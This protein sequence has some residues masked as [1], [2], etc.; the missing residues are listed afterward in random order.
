MQYLNPID[1]DGDHFADLDFDEV[2]R[3]FIGRKWLGIVD[4]HI[5]YRPRTERLALFS[6][7]IA[8][9]PDFNPAT[10]L[11][12]LLADAMHWS[13]ANEIAFD[14]APNTATLHFNNETAICRSAAPRDGL[15]AS[16]RCRRLRRN[17]G[18]ARRD[19]A[20]PNPE[21]PM[22]RRARGEWPL[23]VPMRRQCRRGFVPK[24]SPWRSRRLKIGAKKRP[25]VLDLRQFNRVR[26]SGLEP[27]TYG[28]KV[29]CSTN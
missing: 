22:S 1:S 27:E 11:V 9:Y 16:G 29:R 7:A 28:L 19:P 26:L 12:D 21:F 23:R 15:T 4:Y 6:N 17:H 25:Q 8:C 13:A 20:G 18:S 14:E 2:S 24:L 3:G 5:P 10:N